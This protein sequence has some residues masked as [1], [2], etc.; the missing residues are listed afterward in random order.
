MP[1]KRYSAVYEI[2]VNQHGYAA[3]GQARQAAV[4]PQALAMMAKRGLLERVSRGLY[5][6]NVVP[7]TRFSPYMEAVLWAYPAPGVVSHDSALELFEVSD[8]N[9]DRIHI[10]VPRNFRLRRPVPSTM[11][12]HQADLSAREMTRIQGVPITTAARAIRDCLAANLSARLLLQAIDE[13]SRLGYLTQEDSDALR[14]ELRA[15][16]A[17]AP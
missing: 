4:S 15:P 7:A 6:V 5:R 3:A 2:A 10:T 9:P 13:G 8:V 16:V 1:G 14:L 12:V 11:E 17:V